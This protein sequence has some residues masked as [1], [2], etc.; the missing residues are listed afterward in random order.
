MILVG[1][2]YGGRVFAAI[3]L[4]LS[5]DVTET[6][7][8]PFCRD[9]FVQADVTGLVSGES[10]TGVVE[11]SLDGVGWDNLNSAGEETTVSVNGTTLLA[12]TGAM[13][14]YVRVRGWGDR[15]EGS[16]AAVVLQAHFGIMN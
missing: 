8:C 14:A 13:P 11:G 7:Y 16:V 2:E 4:P 10:L 12:Y 5:D 3:P 6:M 15:V 1:D 9:L